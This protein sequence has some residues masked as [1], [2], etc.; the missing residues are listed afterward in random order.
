MDKKKRIGVQ[1]FFGSSNPDQLLNQNVHFN[2]N[3]NFK[4][5]NSTFIPNPS[6]QNFH[7][8]KRFDND[9]RN[10]QNKPFNKN[11]ERRTDH[12]GEGKLIY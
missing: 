10:Y 6:S 3:Q 11:Y 9:H 2:S 7:N 1:D 4:N 5:E 8:N 12:G